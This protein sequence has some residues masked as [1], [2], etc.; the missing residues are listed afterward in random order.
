MTSPIENKLYEAINTILS[1]L[2]S[3]GVYRGNSHHLTQK[4][5][6]AVSVSLLSKQQKEL[7]DCLTTRPKS[8][9]EISL[10][11]GI[12]SKNV[13]SVLNEIYNKT[14]LLSFNRVGKLKYYYKK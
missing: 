11:S 9:K 8:A 7:Y 1:D 13:S 12:P 4:I 5:T 2:E 14:L 10:E 3:H 6:H